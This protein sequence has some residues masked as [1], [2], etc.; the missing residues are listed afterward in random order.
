MRQSSWMSPHQKSHLSF[1]DSLVSTSNLVHSTPDFR[2]FL[3]W[4]NTMWYCSD[5]DRTLASELLASF[6]NYRQLFKLVIFKRH[7][8][9]G[10]ASFDT[11][12]SEN[13]LMGNLKWLWSKHALS[14]LAAF[15]GQDCLDGEV[16]LYISTCYKHV[17]YWTWT[18]PKQAHI[19]IHAYGYTLSTAVNF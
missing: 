16:W 15:D 7:L 8:L 1:L 19:L 9:L 6:L 17:F 10:I 4:I 2:R 3:E 14:A 5:F 18:C 12:Y 13:S 11:C